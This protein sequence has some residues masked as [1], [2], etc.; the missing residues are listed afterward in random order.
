MTNIQKKWVPSA[1]IDTLKI[2]GQILARIR[3]FF[4]LKDVLEVETPSMSQATVT[5]VHLDTFS[6]K[7]VGPGYAQGVSLFLMTSPEF[8]MKR[9][10]AAGSGSIYQMC[11]SYRNEEAGRT[12]NPEFTML[13]WYRTDFDH[14]QLMDEMDEFLQFLLK[15]QPSERLT[16]QQA[17]IQELGIC[18]LESSMH[19]LRDTAKTMSLSDIADKEEDRD[20]LLQ[21]LFC[22][23]VEP[24][25]GLEKPCM[26][27]DFPASQAALA[28]ISKKD[29]RVAERFEVYY[30]GVELANGFHELAD[31][32]EQ[33]RRFEKD[34]KKRVS[35]G[36]TEQ[37]IDMNFIASLENDFPDCSGVALGVD[38]L[39][40]LALKKDH[41]REVIAFD[42]ERA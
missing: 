31:P 11:R 10:L 42:L 19:E 1:S 5:D 28:Q 9:L 15:T 23:G 26:I 25:I 39:I 33:L 13:E 29:P 38:R 14:Y 40:M 3:H 37:P 21:L 20:T 35:M 41:I 8:H 18:P 34:N 32:K 17:F 7:F 2:R 16:Y 24:K 30:Q 36:L 6:T 27:Y 4:S 12:H 22:I